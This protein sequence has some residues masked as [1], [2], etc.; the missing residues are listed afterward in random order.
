MLRVAHHPCQDRGQ[1]HADQR[2]VQ[3]EV[4]GGV[5]LEHAFFPQIF[6]GRLG[7]RTG[8]IR[9]APAEQEQPSQHY[10]EKGCCLAL[11]MQ[12]L[13]SMVSYHHYTTDSSFLQPRFAQVTSLACTHQRI[14]RSFRTQ[15]MSVMMFSLVRSSL[16]KSV[17]SIFPT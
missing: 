14:S 10:G 4:A 11:H 6:T 8:R 1:L 13:L 15:V 16:E 2:L 17:S 3:H 7:L 12:F 5:A 9:R